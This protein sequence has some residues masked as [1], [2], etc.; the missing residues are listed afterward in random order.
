[1]SRIGNTL[2]GVERQ[3]LN[4]LARSNANI[5]M[6]TLRMTTGHKINSPADNPSAFVQL[7]GLQS[8]LSNASA[9]MNNITVAGSMITQVQAAISGIQ[10][11]LG[12]IR[13]ELAKD[14][15]HTL[16]PDQRAASQ[17]A[18]DAAITQVNKLAATQ[19]YG[20][21]PLSGAG[22]YDFSGRD[23]SQV[24]GVQV[25][26]L[27]TQGQTIS[28]TVTSTATHAELTYTGDSSDLVTDTAV[29]TL[30]GSRGSAVVS[31][32]A[33]DTLAS[34]AA[35]VN[36]NSYL[37]GVTA[38]VDAGAH[39]LILTSVDYGS[40]AKT[41]IAVSSGAFVTTGDTAGT[42]ASAVINGQTIDATSSSV[43][44]NSF[45]INDNGFSFDIE[46]KAGFTGGFNQITVSGNALT[47]ALSPDLNQRS[48]LAIS[49]MYAAE[50][51]GASGSL[52]QLATGGSL[53]GLGNN[54]AQ[55]IRVVDEA[56]GDATVVS[57]NVNGFYKS[58][59]TSASTLMTALQT[60]LQKEIERIDKT[61]DAQESTLIAHYQVLASNA[62]SSLSILNHQQE[63][64]AYMIRSIAGLSYPGW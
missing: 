3:L 14:V 35:T 2:S 1:M 5:A 29:F 30:S 20:K 41:E 17:N 8:Q 39:E 64:I 11:Q 15:N 49:G 4:S 46:F 26:N 32:T 24:T 23:S 61:D 59:I 58:A 21:S 55:A 56:L 31:V 25:H 19:I 10:T 57:G 52:D 54:T 50:L 27:V 43:N 18:I 62:L 53:S 16:T 33:G 45:S 7:S 63:E 13:T 60:D 36:N 47:F 34:V 42:N 40:Q 38:S 28:G 9:A 51:G 37:T 6:S 48:T 44:G 22:N 12:V